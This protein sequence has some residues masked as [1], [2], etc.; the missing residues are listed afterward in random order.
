MMR[1]GMTSKLLPALALLALLPFSGCSSDSPSEPRRDPPPTPGA[2]P[3]AQFN[4]TVTPQP[5]T[6]TSGSEDLSTIIVRVRRADNGAVPATGTNVLVSTT[7]GTFA[8]GS[9]Q[10]LLTLVNGEARANLLPPVDPNVE[11][12]AVVPTLFMRMFGWN[13]LTVGASAQVIP[14]IAGYGLNLVATPYVVSQLGLHDFGVWAMT[15]AIAQYAALLEIWADVAHADAK[16]ARFSLLRES[17]LLA[18]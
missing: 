10:V 11:G 17:G 3:A 14:L 18:L 12:T 16:W 5:P 15:G 7:L 9:Q 8:D 4:V 2:P 13:T 1:I 6:I